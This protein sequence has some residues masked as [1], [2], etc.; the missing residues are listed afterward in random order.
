MSVV[1]FGRFFRVCRFGY[2]TVG[3]T[4]G[5]AV[6]GQG[7]RTPFTVAMHCGVVMC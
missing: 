7:N 1:P 2:E 5:V 6:V 4:V 3:D